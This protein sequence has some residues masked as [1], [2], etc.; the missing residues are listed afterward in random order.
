[1]RSAARPTIVMAA[2]MRACA[3]ASTLEMKPG[4]RTNARGQVSHCYR[5]MVHL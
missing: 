2:L 5:A 3:I 1:M 4:L